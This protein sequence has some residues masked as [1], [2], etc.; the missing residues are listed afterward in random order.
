MIECAEYPCVLVLVHAPWCVHCKSF[1]PVF[2]RVARA[3]ATS[4]STLKVCRMDGD[5]N[6]VHGL[7]IASFPTLFVFPALDKSE[8]GVVKFGGESGWTAAAVLEWA[9]KATTFA[10]D[11]K[12]RTRVAEGL[13]DIDKKEEEEGGGRDGASTSHSSRR[14]GS[15]EEL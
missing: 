11:A 7:D 10:F 14:S 2:E 13:T 5:K 6:D 9:A 15:K 1:N 12:A 8:R 4:V 3:I